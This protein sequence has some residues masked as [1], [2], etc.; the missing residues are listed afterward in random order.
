M[1]FGDKNQDLTSSI[2]GFKRF[3]IPERGKALK[4]L[5]ICYQ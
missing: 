1:V 3:D 2:E 4:A 5:R